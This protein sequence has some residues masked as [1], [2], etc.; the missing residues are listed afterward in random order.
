MTMTLSGAVGSRWM[1]CSSPVHDQRVVPSFKMT[2]LQGVSG[3]EEPVRATTLVY[4]GKH[5]GSP[6]STA[7][8]TAIDM[9]TSDFCNSLSSH[10]LRN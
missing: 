3:R 5:R 8:I 1:S 2:C 9:H 4:A 10:A 6:Q 7:L